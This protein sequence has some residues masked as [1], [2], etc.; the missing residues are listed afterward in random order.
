MQGFFRIKQGIQSIFG[1]LFVSQLLFGLSVLRFLR[2][3]LLTCY[4]L[5]GQRCAIL[6]G[7]SNQRVRLFFLCI[8]LHL[9][10]CSLVFLCGRI[11]HPSL[12]LPFYQYIPLSFP[13]KKIYIRYLYTHCQT[14]QKSTNKQAPSQVKKQPQLELNQS[15]KLTKVKG[16]SVIKNKKVFESLD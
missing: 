4:N 13:I 3:Y 15:I 14:G 11:P 9:I 16:R 12:V 7:W 6:M 2:G 10:T 1:I 5:I 8:F